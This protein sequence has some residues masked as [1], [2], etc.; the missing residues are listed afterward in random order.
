MTTRKV[1]LR[2]KIKKK[3]NKILWDEINKTYPKK[4][5]RKR[6][7]LYQELKL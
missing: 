6:I 4:L 7:K 3:G 2:N 1:A 5:L